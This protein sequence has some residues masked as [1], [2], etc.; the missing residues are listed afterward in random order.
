[1]KIKIKIKNG[2]II[3]V[4]KEENKIIDK[5]NFTE[6]HNLSEKLLLNIDKLLKKNKINNKRVKKI[7]LESDIGEP[8]TTYRIAKTIAKTFNWSIKKM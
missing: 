5:L 4:L 1:M 3:L 2:Q 7:E 6:E 8:Y